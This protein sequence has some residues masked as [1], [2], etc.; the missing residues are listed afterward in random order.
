MGM[1]HSHGPLARYVKLLVAYALGMLETFPPPPP[2]CMS[3]SLTRGGEENVP[4]IPGAC[5][6]RNCTYVVRGLWSVESYDLYTL[7]GSKSSEICL[8]IVIK[9]SLILTQAY[10]LLDI[11]AFSI[12][13]LYQD[14]IFKCMTEIFVLNFE[15]IFAIPCMKPC[16]YN[17][18]NLFR[19][20]VK[21]W[22]LFDLTHWGRVTHICVSKLTIIGSDNG[23]SPGRRQANIW[24]NAGILLMRPLETN[25]SEILIEIDAFSVKKIH[26]K[27]SSGKLRPFCL[28][29]NELRDLVCIWSSPDDR[30]LGKQLRHWKY[31]QNTGT[32]T[33]AVYEI[34][35][36]KDTATLRVILLNVKWKI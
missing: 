18:N 33:R 2:W 17:D 11:T 4:S 7:F 30:C 12:S 32:S 34:L 29:L 31:Y 9:L 6:T 36:H 13:M 8:Q 21:I 20:Y 5:T 26:L 25:F 27:M 35:Q 1:L 28:G 14:Q 24:T 15:G 22:E 3:G 19:W 10:G 16:P 23:L